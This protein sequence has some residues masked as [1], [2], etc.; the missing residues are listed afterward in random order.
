TAPSTAS[1]Q[2]TSTASPQPPAPS[3]EYR[4]ADAPP[5]PSPSFSPVEQEKTAAPRPS[6]SS[7]PDTA[8]LPTPGWPLIHPAATASL[9]L[10]EGR[11]RNGRT[12]REIAVQ[13]PCAQAPL[14]RVYLEKL[15]GPTYRIQWHNPDPG[16]GIGCLAVDGASTAPGALIAP[17]DCVDSAS[18]KFRLEASGSGFRLRPVHSGLCVG[19]LPPVTD[20][21]EALQTPCTAASSQ[22]FTFTKN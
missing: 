14:P 15:S 1:K 10:T 4:T 13:H 12:D 18:Q 11:E 6:H 5:A 22:A 7:G 9:C 8:R 16:K 20:G 19:F 17:R 21:A 3:A 2:T